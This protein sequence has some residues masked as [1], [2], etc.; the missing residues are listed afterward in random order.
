M[1]SESRPPGAVATWLGFVLSHHRADDGIGAHCW[2]IGRA[3]PWVCARCLGLYPA[4]GLALVLEPLWFPTLALGLRTVALALTVTPAW[5]A[6]AHDRLRPEAPW[7][8][9]AATLTAVPAGLGTGVW[10]WSHIRDP[11]HEAFTFSLALVA[12]L[13]LAVWG[14]GRFLNDDA[15]SIPRPPEGPPPSDMDV[16][17]GNPPPSQ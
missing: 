2:R 15:G 7:P 16:E 10:L 13:S 4:M 5:L 12:V 1:T 6:W 8:R 11:F 14:L 17:S 3:G 9:A